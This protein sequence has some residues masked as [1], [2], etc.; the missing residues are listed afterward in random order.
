MMWK[1]S[2]KIPEN[3]FA[4]LSGCTANPVALQF[5]KSIG[6]FNIYIANISLS[7][8]IKFSHKDNVFQ[9]KSAS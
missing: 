2:V 5:L 8:R 9:Q 6:I 1:P 7:S 3:S 4:V